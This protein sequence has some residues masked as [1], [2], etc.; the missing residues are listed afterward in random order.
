MSSN[1]V[2][3]DFG[4]GIVA[5]AGGSV[6]ILDYEGLTS[7]TAIV[8]ATER[9]ILDGGRVSSV[10]AGMRR[11]T[12]DLDF[13]ETEVAWR[14]LG[15]LFPVGAVMRL[16]VT[17]SGRTCYVTAYRDGDIIPLGGRGVLD[18]VACQVSLLSPDPF[19]AGD[20]AELVY[21]AAIT[22][23][24]TFPVTFGPIT[25]ETMD[26]SAGTATYVVENV[27]DRPVGFSVDFIA[28][29][30]TTPV[31]SLGSQSMA[32]SELSAGQR[33]QI[34]TSRQT[35]RVDGANGYAQLV[36]GSF[37]KIPT[38]L[39]SLLLEGFKGP[40]TIEFTPIFEGV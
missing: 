32:F 18:P 29:V 9:A 13:I 40:A 34:D 31:L 19:L 25:Y 5:G 39:S 38:G 15:R 26:V 10:R 30:A 16:A 7:P 2:T 14:D 28:A 20:T 11:L 8:N 36:S 12:F 22:A 3:V 27:G 24:L 33:L 1:T 17:R 4:N 21:A 37:I 23:G 6:R 35:V